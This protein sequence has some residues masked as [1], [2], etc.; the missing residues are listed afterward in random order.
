MT[1]QSSQPPIK[2]IFHRKKIQENNTNS[3]TPRLIRIQFTDCDATDSS[4]SD[5]DE[6]LKSHFRPRIKKQVNEIVIDKKS[7]SSSINEKRKKKKKKRPLMSN[8]IPR[9]DQGVGNVKKFRGVR[10]RPWGKWAAEIR[11][12]VRKTRIWLGTYETAEEAAMVYDRAA[13]QL[14]GPDALTNF[15][16][17]P[18]RERPDSVS[19]YDSGKDSENNRLCSPTSVLSRFKDNKQQQNNTSKLIENKWAGDWRPVEPVAK[20]NGIN[21]LDDD[22]SLLLDDQCLLNDYFN[23]RSPSPLIYDEII[24]H[25]EVDAVL[26]GNFDD[27]QFNFVLGVDDDDD[28]ESSWALDVNDFLEDQLL[29][30]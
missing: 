29:V 6:F 7:C 12:T 16:K 11:D 21:F 23:L 30:V 5:E 19:D 4:S 27:T 13:I 1:Q 14:R 8:I 20:G 9:C 28:L 3:K 17:P 10:Q 15:I 2:Y 18:D 24:G 26:K 22:D 25:N